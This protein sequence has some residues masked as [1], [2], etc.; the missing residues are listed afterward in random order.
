MKLFILIYNQLNL[1]FYP[2][3]LIVG[4]FNKKIQIGIKGRKETFKKLE[5]WQNNIDTNNYVILVN[6][7]SLG[8]YEQA[9][10]I[11]EKIK[12]ENKNVKIALSFF[13]PSGFENFK[14]QNLI[15]IYFYLPFDLYWK[16]SKLLK[17]LKPKAII[18]TSYD[19]WPNMVY[20]SDKYNIKHY[21]ISARLKEN[22]SKLKPILKSFF[23]KIFSFYRKIFTVSDMDYK[24]FYS[25]LNSSDNIV[26]IGDTRF[27]NVEKRFQKFKDIN[28]FP[29]AW[30][31]EK[32]II[33]GS[34]HHECYNQIIPAIKSLQHK[35][36]N[37]HFVIAPHDLDENV[38]L[39]FKN[40]LKNLE[41]LS[42]IS[43][44]SKAQNIYVD[45]IGDLAKLYF[46]SD[47]AYI[48]GGF[49]NDG[50]H[51]VMEPAVSGIPIFIGPKNSNSLEAQELKKKGA[52][53][54]FITSEQL[55]SR[56]NELLNDETEYNR[57]STNARE[58]IVNSL[59]SS[60]KI[61]EYLKNDKII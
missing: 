57:I 21:L 41:K 59:G 1:L 9:K 33:F 30:K 13:S 55:I 47:F 24:L 36:K 61:I 17:L 23:K 32:V 16:I 35:N 52:I 4:L 38:F 39:M 44:E 19:V 50:L 3:I 49:G 10:P 28:L 48:G 56:I 42:N 5:K 37:L 8:E 53:Y 20:L 46:S 25:L 15:D 27:D 12:I 51:N 34:T 2:L 11:I 14:D 60:A 18:D 29:I 40:E 6:C 45:T 22:T 43:A 7:S 58:Y 26:N 54:E 31:D